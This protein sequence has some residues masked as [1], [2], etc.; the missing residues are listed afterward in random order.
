M[1]DYGIL[2]DLRSAVLILVFVQSVC[3][4]LASFVADG[5]DRRPDVAALG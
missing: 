3:L 4:L 2:F 5:W 1:A